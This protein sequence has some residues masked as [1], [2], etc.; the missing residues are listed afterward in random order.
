MFQRTPN[1][2]P[3]RQLRLTDAAVEE[4]R[5]LCSEPDGNALCSIPDDPGCILWTGGDNGR[6]WGRYCTGGQDAPAHHYAW[7][8]AFGEIPEDPGVELD[9][10]CA[11]RRCVSVAHLE[12]V[13]QLENTRRIDLRRP[14]CRRGHDWSWGVP[15][16]R[17]DSPARVCFQC[18]AEGPARK[19]DRRRGHKSK[20]SRL[21]K[22]P[23]GHDVTGDKGYDIEGLPGRRGCWICTN[24]WRA[25]G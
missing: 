20:A 15:Y 18:V 1:P 9:H 11:V 23:R 17:P 21:V 12:W 10:L 16:F 13:T 7:A 24:A 3:R 8:I 19:T 25:A 4:F 5:A 6:G 14:T 2:S 22:C